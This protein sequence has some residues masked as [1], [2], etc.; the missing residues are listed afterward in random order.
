MLLNLPLN[1]SLLIA[2]ITKVPK[3]MTCA[4]DSTFPFVHVKEAWP[5]LS[6]YYFLLLCIYYY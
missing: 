6:Y 4:R 2:L 1:H 3:I 5:L